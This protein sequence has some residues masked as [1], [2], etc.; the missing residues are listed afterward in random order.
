MPGRPPRSE[1][2]RHAE[3]SPVVP[4]NQRNLRI[5]RIGEPESPL[6]IKGEHFP[7]YGEPRETPGARIRRLE[8]RRVDVDRHVFLR[9][10]AQ[11][12]EAHGS[13]R[14]P[15]GS[16]TEAGEQLAVVIEI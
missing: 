5:A 13:A 11:S 3:L 8:P 10:T 15:D 12:D 7:F 1:N 4:S 14:R 9:H 2:D 16:N 6:H